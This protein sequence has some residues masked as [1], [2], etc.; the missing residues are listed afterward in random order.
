MRRARTCFALALALSGCSE[1]RAPGGG[2]PAASASLP[3]LAP[4]GDAPAASASA[5]S[6][7]APAASAST[8]PGDAPAASA[9][10]PP[11]DAT[12]DAPGASAGA[13]VQRIVLAKGDAFELRLPPGLA[14][15]PAA[16]GLKRARFMAESPDG[17]LFV[18]DMIDLSD[19]RRGIVYALDGFDPATRTFAR[20]VPYL[21][22]LRNPN[23]VAF[24]REGARSWLYV[25]L[26]DRLVRYPYADGAPAPAGPP[27]TLATFPDYGLNY[28]YGGWHLTRTVTF[29][30]DGTLYVSAGSSCNACEETEAVRATVSA[31]GAAGEGARIFARGLRNAVGL[32]WANGRLFATNM[33]ADHLGDNVPDDALYALTDGAHYGWP[34][35]YPAG[36]R[37][38]ADP[39]F[40]ASEQRVDCTQVP[41]P[42]AR[43]GAHAS[44]LGFEFFENSA[45]LAEVRGGFVVALH[46][47]TKK[48]IGRGYKL[49][50]VAR[51][52]PPEDLITGFLEGTAVHGRPVDVVRWGDGFLFTDDFAGVVYFVGR[53]ARA[54]G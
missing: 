29:G 41:A 33:G 54:G 48:S 9:S 17:R 24:R 52:R 43:F 14:I 28:K 47:S 13:G 49:V 32:R 18:T 5:P 4:S 25:A 26:T 19:N 53:A 44:P 12:S 7:D 42:L 6:G 34:Y 50:R 16:E 15:T 45:P 37:T 3:A 11:G 39:K 2:G 51:G 35:C 21:T 40:A 22:G 8:P 23:S 10:A 30:G 27:E 38:L 1:R 36:A 31:M 20:R 46:G